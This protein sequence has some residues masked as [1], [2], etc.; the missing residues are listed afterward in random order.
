MS[1]SPLPPSSTAVPGR[2]PPGFADSHAHVGDAAFDADRAEVL[3]RFV[4]AGG[5][6]LI[7]ASE[8]PASARK[9]LSLAERHAFVYGIAGMHPHH[10][11]EWTEE[12]VDEIDSLLDHPKIRAVG[13]IGLDYHYDFSPPVRQRALFERMLELARRRKLPA[14]IHNRESDADMLTLLGAYPDVASRSVMHC[15]D[16]PDDTARACLDLGMVLSFSGIVTFKKAAALRK[17]V[18]YVPRDKLL[19]ETDCPYLAPHP[20]RGRRNEPAFAAFVARRVADIRNEDFGETAER[21]LENTIRVFGVA[22]CKTSF[23]EIE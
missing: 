22:D 3:E 23:G 11:A 19:I 17:I 14:V 10:A 13:E 20:E 9:V 15:F 7:A 21:T 2:P 4:E 1:A 12:T 6:I 8:N 16:A 18:A 5:R